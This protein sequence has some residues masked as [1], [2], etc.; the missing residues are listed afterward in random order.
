MHTK[1]NKISLSV[2]HQL[3]KA[4]PEE[5]ADIILQLLKHHP[6]HRLELPATDGLQADLKHLDLSKSALESRY[7]LDKLE[8][9]WSKTHNGM[10]M[11]M[12]NIPG[13]NLKDA[14][15]QNSYLSSSNLR[16]SRMQHANLT[17]IELSNADL[18]KAHLNK[19]RI[20]NAD[21]IYSN[22][23][24]AVLEDAD[25][26]GS[27]LS[28]ADLEGADLK[29]ADLTGANLWRAN[30][31]RA[32]LDHTNFSGADLKEVNFQEAFFKQTE[33][34][35]AD[36][37]Y[38]KLEGTKLQNCGLSHTRI[39]GAILQDAVISSAQFGDKIGEEFHI[40]DYGNDPEVIIGG[41]EEA[42]E[43]YVMLINRFNELSDRESILWALQR[44][45]QM[46]K[47]I[48]RYNTEL[49][50]KN[51]HWARAFTFFMQYINAALFQ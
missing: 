34:R 12:T 15:L 35:N 16:Q 39:A 27:F 37:R 42:R 20:T 29:G 43:A 44:E 22:L 13:S 10:N 26:T 30:L 3:Q 33:F 38:A 50:W 19:T 40:F 28:F 32:N 47:Q 49:A 46:E 45:K 31:S 51:K 23:K 1:S 25:L 17:G 18:E 5:K 48:L 21:L 24:G 14:N 4:T 11:N 6:E 41:Y 8:P 9:F 2:Y 7:S 36:L